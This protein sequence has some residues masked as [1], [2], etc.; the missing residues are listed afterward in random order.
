[1]VFLCPEGGRA[2]PFRGPSEPPGMR[3]EGMKEREWSEAIGCI[4]LGNHDAKMEILAN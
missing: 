1:M 3:D 2:S 4:V